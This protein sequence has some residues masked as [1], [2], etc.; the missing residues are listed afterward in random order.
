MLVKL[1]EFVMSELPAMKTAK[2]GL[3][4]R[5]DRLEAHMEQKA[6]KQDVEILNKKMDMMLEGM[7]ALTKEF[8]IIRS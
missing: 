4:V 5:M 6:D 3:Q 2:I 7:D 8:D 1:A